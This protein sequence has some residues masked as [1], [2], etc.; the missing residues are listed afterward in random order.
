MR[1]FLFIWL[2]QL[3]SLLGS[4]LTNFALGIWVYQNTGSVTLFAL[5]S[6]FATLPYMVISPV[7][8]ALV[9]R[10][11]RQWVMI[12]SDLGAGIATLILTI[13][14]FTDHLEIWHIYL[15]T[16]V[17]SFF[18]A[19]Q[20][21]AYIAAT[22]LIVPKRYL[23]RASG[24]VQLGEAVSQ[25]FAPILAGLLIVTIKLDGI[26]LIDFATFIFAVVTLFVVQFPHLDAKIT[27][28]EGK[29]S[30]LQEAFLGWTYLTARPGLLALLLFFTT[31]NLL[32]G[33]VSVLVTPLVLSFAS[34]TELGMVMSIGG[35][36]MLVGS[37]VM[38]TWGG[39]P[40]HIN[41]VFG[42]MFLSGLCVVA[43][44]LRAFI[45]LLIVAA[46]L[47]FFGMPIING[48]SQIIFQKKVAPQMQGRVFAFNLAFRTASLPIAYGI[49]GPLADRIFEPL[50]AVNGPLAST[51]GH[52]IGTGDGRGIALIFIIMGFLTMLATIA[53]YQY[54][55]L[56]FVEDQ[57]PDIVSEVGID[58]T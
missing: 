14:L 48:S 28:K 32:V 26:I 29:T 33:V 44:G 51:I 35:T 49:A 53:A 23:S 20:K 24:M 47:A 19:F 54:P 55:P 42:F 18:G 43:A 36:G 25:L 10:W 38:S 21:P 15:I 12:I 45:P 4:G 22:T 6:L 7:A 11:N 17:N 30:V 2:G 52:I 41:A 58:K 9:D 40:R 27:K 50:M 16:S 1:L 56:R 8:G 5:I 34:P 46:F 39:P 57:L 31:N 37:L 13:L 3:I